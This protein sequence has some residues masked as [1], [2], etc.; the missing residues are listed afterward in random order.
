M[1]GVGFSFHKSFTGAML[2]YEQG[3]K[4]IQ[5]CTS[6]TLSKSMGLMPE[7]PTS[8]SIS[9]GLNNIVA[10]DTR[11]EMK[12]KFSSETSSPRSNSPGDR[13]KLQVW[14]ALKKGISSSLAEGSKMARNLYENNS[15]NPQ[16]TSVSSDTT[17]LTSAPSKSFSAK[18]QIAMAGVGVMPMTTAHD[19]RMDSRKKD[20][21]GM[22]NITSK[23]NN[24]SL[25]PRAV[26]ATGFQPREHIAGE[27]HRRNESAPS[28]PISSKDIEQLRSR[29]IAIKEKHEMA[30]A[31]AQGFDRSK[32]RRNFVEEQTSNQVAVMEKVTLAQLPVGFNVTDAKS[33]LN[34]SDVEKL[35]KQAKTQA[36]KFRVF[37]YHEVKALSKELREL[38]AHCD[39]IRSTSRALRA[40]RNNF[41]RQ[42]IARLRSS[43][44]ATDSRE[45]ILGEEEAI[46]QL[47]KSI[48]EWVAKL[49]QVD[50]R[51]TR[52]RQM[53]LEHIAA[54]LVLSAAPLDI[55]QP[56]INNEVDAGCTDIARESIRIYADYGVYGD[57]DMTGLLADIEHQIETMNGHQVMI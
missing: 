14:P 20:G 57:A 9:I 35:Q 5:C 16:L 56:A 34:S 7:S 53:L 10:R 2:K 50:N 3:L 29:H 33:Q 4:H 40:G 1:S 17:Q 31:L 26:T 24:A 39:Y 55:K 23:G 48:D 28:V 30:E 45:N 36:E 12:P 25:R 38:D 44:S 21:S 27:L 37:Q 15:S 46:A 41:H 8:V 19:A 47:D 43:Q 13:L 52:V 54:S 22:Y 11:V 18:R 32:R 6:A 42:V 51:R 49:E